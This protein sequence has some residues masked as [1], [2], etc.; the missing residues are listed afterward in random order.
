MM[1]RLRQ[2]SA[3][4]H[5]SHFRRLQ[6][7]WA[8]SIGLG[9]YLGDADDATDAR[10][11]EA[12]RAALA[13]GCNVL[14]T[15]VNYRCQ[16]S[17]RTIGRTLEA[18][19]TE[20]TLTRDEVILCTK[21]GYLPFDGAVPD[22]PGRCLVETV[23]TP[24]LASYEEIVA[25]C[26]CLAP[27]YLDHM[28]RLS[29]ANLRVAALD[30]YYLHNPEQQLDEI[31]PEPFLQRL[32]AAFALLEARAQEGAFRYYGVATWNGLRGRPGGRGQLSLEAL[33]R[34]AERLGGDDHHFRVIQLPYNLAMPEAFT[35]A[36]Q[37][38]GGEP[39]TVLQAAARLGLSVVTSAGLL[40][41]R[42]TRLPA[43]FESHIPGLATAPQRALQF[44]R[45][46]PG[47][48]TALAGMS[49]R[50]HV[51][52]NLSLTRQPLLDEESIRRLFDRTKW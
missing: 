31:G 18:L 44:A 12:I 5:P 7:L 28:L 26:H 2:R 11:A 25:G 30:V 15:A 41:S 38:V 50:A 48:T 51:E 27:A 46:T 33:V 29:L 52:E 49:R 17:E 40:Q 20:G 3:S 1:K 39:M 4:C 45:S 23:I 16:R 37:V 10:Y 21:G 22:D 9:T 43:S 32:E 36:N 42:L 13:Q 8:S 47:V 24:G 35:F 6:N 19:C 34:L 14:D